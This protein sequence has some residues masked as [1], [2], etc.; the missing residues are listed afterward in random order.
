MPPD[1]SSGQSDT[2]ALT[3]LHRLPKHHQVHAVDNPSPVETGKATDVQLTKAR[4]NGG[5]N[6][7]QN[8]DGA[9]GTM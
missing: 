7:S 5:L 8:T 9:K 4:Q 2:G 1:S 6:G 3:T